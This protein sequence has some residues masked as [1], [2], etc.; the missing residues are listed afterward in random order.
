MQKSTLVNIV[1]I[2]LFFLTL[3]LPISIAQPVKICSGTNNKKAFDYYNKASALMMEGRIAE[4][5]PYFLK[6]V[7]E[8]TNYVDAYMRLSNIYLRMK[9][10]ELEQQ[11]YEKVIRICPAL[12]GAHFNYAH[13]LMRQ[14]EYELAIKSFEK[15]LTFNDIS[16]DFYKKALQNIRI[17]EFR[18]SCIK[19]PV[20]FNP[21]NAGAGINTELDEYWPAITADDYSLYF[22]RKLDQNP[23]AKLD[24][25]RYNE[26][27]FVS[28]FENKTWS[29]ARK[30]PSYLNAVDKNEGAIT[31]SP[32]GKY[33]LFTICSENQDFGYGVCDIY[34]S[35]FKNGEW[36]KYKNIGPPINSAAKETQPSISYDG[37]TIY[38]SSNRGGTL[39]KLDIWK[40][41]RKPDGSWNEPV[42]LGPEING[43]ENEQSPFIHPD[44][45]TLYFSS[46][47]RLGMG[48]A[49]LYVAR[50]NDLGQ[51]GKVQNLGYPIN[52]DK[53]EISIIVNAM[54]DKAYFASRREGGYG[55]LDIYSFNIPSHI[56]PKPVCY[57]KGIVFDKETKAPLAA[58]FELIDLETGKTII[59]S[60]SDSKTGRFLI[61]IPAGKNYLINASKSGYLFY[62]DNLSSKGISSS[63]FEKQ[64]PMIPIRVGETLILNNIFFDFDKSTIKPESFIELKKVVDFLNLHQNI[65]IEI[66]GHTDSYG[67]D[68]YNLKLSE[69]RAKA[70]YEYLVNSGKIEANRISYK[71]YGETKPIDSNETEAGRAKNRRTEFKILAF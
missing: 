12:P 10:V 20:D 53:S 56:R 47:S 27:I 54:G 68:T 46:E 15:F 22:T 5:E 7:R 49:D 48:E 4:A 21:E 3:W 37:N 59:N 29:E 1:V 30:L 6:A 50:K 34:I 8:D 28:Y 31:I 57:L 58:K 43:P 17:C 9:K 41:T 26:D 55:G 60:E 62:S 24:F 25:Y 45:Q 16:E 2:I 18:D 44:D 51:F 40:S 70:V 13:L 61:A 63:A 66:G 64:I 67:D 38:F 36:Q 69:A 32:D 19:N 39:G 11:Q 35:E 71:G 14:K 33:L 52:S 23:E 42:N 65:K